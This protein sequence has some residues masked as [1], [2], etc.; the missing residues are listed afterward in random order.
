MNIDRSAID[1]DYV[2]IRNEYSTGNV[3]VLLVVFQNHGTIDSDPIHVNIDRSAIDSDYVNI[4]NEYS[5]IDRSTTDSD[6]G[7]YD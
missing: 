4:R 1:S 3:E 6:Y 2:N 5:I 7:K